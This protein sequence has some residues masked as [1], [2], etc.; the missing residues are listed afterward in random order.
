[1]KAEREGG[2]G[3]FDGDTYVFRRGE[4]RDADDEPDAWVDELGDGAG[5]SGAADGAAASASEIS[6]ASS[7][8]R[9]SAKRTKKDRSSLLDLE[10]VSY[11]EL[12]NRASA[13]LASDTET[14][15]RAL[16]RYGDVIARD[17]KRRQ[18]AAKAAKKKAG[19]PSSAGPNDANA[20]NG[21]DADAAADDAGVSA[22]QKALSE[23]TELADAILMGGDS[24]IYSRNRSDL[25][26]S[27][28]GGADATG[29]EH[30]AGHKRKRNYFSEE[31][32]GNVIP[33]TNATRSDETA[34]STPP[35]AS[36]KVPVQWEYRGNQDNQIHGPYTTEQMLG[37]IRAGYFVGETA[38][39]VRRIKSSTD[40]SAGA[41]PTV[42]S[43]D[44]MADLMDSDDDDGDSKDKEGGDS[45]QLWE[46]SDKVD[47]QSYL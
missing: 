38:V 35:A 7:I 5:A 28:S 6:T 37:W 32:D 1:M 19:T 17:R 22:A 12:C 26:K 44:L 43:D 27:A 47:F 42:T 8:A 3:Y 39:D 29:D 16:K 31:Q 2:E 14:V 13:L 11:E 25:M 10:D 45:E 30:E 24:E 40:S 4:G 20:K 18:E 21:K 15:A 9:I 41:E 23:L 34:T 46:K 36:T 33:I